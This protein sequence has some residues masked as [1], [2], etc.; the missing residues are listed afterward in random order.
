MAGKVFNVSGETFYTCCKHRCNLSPGKALYYCSQ[1][2]GGPC[3]DLGVGNAK[4]WAE[5]F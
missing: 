2:E 3:K 4:K 1:R 5:S